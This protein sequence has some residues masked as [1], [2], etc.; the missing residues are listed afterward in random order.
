[1]HRAQQRVVRLVHARGLVQLAERD[2]VRVDDR[3]RDR[4]DRGR[5]AGSRRH[6][7]R[8]ARARAGAEQAEENEQHEQTHR[9]I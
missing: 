5:L 4:V 9:H 8:A 2:E 6:D 7:P 1:M 3:S